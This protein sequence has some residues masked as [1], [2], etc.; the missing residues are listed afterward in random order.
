MREI[1]TIMSN[2]IRIWLTLLGFALFPG[3]AISAGLKAAVSAD[4]AILI[5]GDTGQTLFEKNA[6]AVLFPASITK[7]ATALYI[8]DKY[9]HRL[10]EEASANATA[11]G[12]APVHLK[13]SQS[14]RYPSYLLESG[15]THIG[16]Q[17]GEK[18]SVEALLHGLLIGSA[19]DAANVLAEHFCGSVPRFMEELNAYLLSKGFTNTH[20]DN[21]HGLYHAEHTTSARDMAGIAKEAMKFPLFR[22]IVR[23]EKALKPQTNKQ[24]PYPY[25]QGNLLVRPG[26]YFYPHATG[27]KTGYTFKSK[28]TLVASAEKDQRKVIAV[29]LGCQTNEHRYKD[30]ITL[31]EAAFGEKK[32]SRLLL[33]KEYDTFSLNVKGAQHPLKAEMLKDLVLDYYPSEEPQAHTVVE[34]E[35]S[36]FPIQKGQIVGSI[37]LRDQ[38]N[39]LLKREP[40][41]AIERVDPTLFWKVRH[42][43]GVIATMKL[44]KAIVL[45][46]M[47]VTAIAGWIYFRL[48][49]LRDGDTVG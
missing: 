49:K 3:Q 36:R 31:F 37:A 18:L 15:A 48:K 10:K 39:V 43:A 5:N 22:T 20:F 33:T 32:T 27:I 45:A 19:N 47:I 1:W 29:V 6:D 24:P 40:L 12:W 13:R 7:V 44:T 30:A 34:W 9:G 26:K 46:M 41:V 8:L 16:I 42:Y 21:P 28:C 23:M 17:T 35:V 25:A 38:N 2:C 14:S 4:A 11:L